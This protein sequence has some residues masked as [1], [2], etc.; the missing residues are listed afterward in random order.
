MGEQPPAGGAGVVGRRRDQQAW[1]T[2]AAMSWLSYG[3]VVTVAVPFLPPTSRDWV[4]GL[5]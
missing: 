4:I 5:A 1:L 2:P 3:L